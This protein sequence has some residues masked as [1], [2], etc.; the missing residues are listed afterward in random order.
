M[1]DVWHP[2]QGPHRSQTPTETLREQVKRV[3]MPAELYDSIGSLP[4]TL[5]MKH[6]ERQAVVIVED[7]ESALAAI[8]SGVQPEIVDMN[9]DEIFEAYVIGRRDERHDTKPALER[10]A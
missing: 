8:P 1:A 9:L 3:I 5:D 2:R 4:G 10:V 6:R 7:I